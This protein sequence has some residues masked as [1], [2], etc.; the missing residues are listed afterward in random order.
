MLKVNKDV[1]LNNSIIESVVILV[2]RIL[3]IQTSVVINDF[4]VMV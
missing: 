1:I 2:N 3:I 4:Y